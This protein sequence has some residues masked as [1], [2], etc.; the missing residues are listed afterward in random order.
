MS[1]IFHTS[2]HVHTRGLAVIYLARLLQAVTLSESADAALEGPSSGQV[3]TC[4]SCTVHSDM[5]ATRSA[6]TWL[7]QLFLLQ[8]LR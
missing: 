8:Q 3:T 1:M 6:N 5:P 7:H 2:S 4:Q